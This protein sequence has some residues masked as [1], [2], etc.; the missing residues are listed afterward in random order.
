MCYWPTD[1]SPVHSTYR[2]M[3]SY[4]IGIL[5]WHSYTVSMMHPPSSTH[6]YNPH[7]CLHLCIIDTPVSTTGTIY[8]YWSAIWMMAGM[9]YRQSMMSMSHTLAHIL[10]TLLTQMCYPGSTHSSIHRMMSMMNN[11]SIH[12]LTNISRICHLLPTVCS[13]M[14]TTNI[15]RNYCMS[16]R[17]ALMTGTLS[18]CLYPSG[19]TL[20]GT[21]GILV[22]NCKWGTPIHYNDNIYYPLYADKTQYC[23]NYML[24]HLNMLYNSM[25]IMYTHSYPIHSTLSSIAGRPTSY[26]PGRAVCRLYMCQLSSSSRLCRM[27]TWGWQSS[28]HKLCS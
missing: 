14:N 28:H 2:L 8:N 20:V 13:Q 7:M 22:R 10:Y 9:W 16:S 25:R 21:I 12:L 18:M 3:T 15:V 4:R 19:R 6:L 27:C 11:R 5:S 23:M 1:S 26:R 17:I 24:M